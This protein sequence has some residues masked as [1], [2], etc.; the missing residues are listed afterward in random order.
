MPV[1]IKLPSVEAVLVCDPAKAAGLAFIE[2]GRVSASAIC[3]GSSFHTLSEKMRVVLT[4]A[5]SSVP[6]NQTLFLFEA[7][8]IGARSQ[9]S[10]LT[11][12]LRRG[13][14][15]AAAEACGLFRFASVSPSTWQNSLFGSLKGRD[16]KQLSVAYAQSLGL[17]PETD[18]E[19][20]A[21]C[22]ATW[23]W[24]KRNDL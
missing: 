5:K 20:D 21:I 11:L 23:A 9:K 17:S 13:L 14:A 22:I 8:W 12:Q 6:L 15:V 24:S 4:A 18:D 3:D 1:K 19:A 10:A 2:G 7:G 16:T